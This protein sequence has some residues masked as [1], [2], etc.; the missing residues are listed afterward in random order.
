MRLAWSNRRVTAKDVKTALSQA[1]MFSYV[2]H[3]HRLVQATWL[4]LLIL[5]TNKSMTQS[6]RKD[7]AG[8]ISSFQ[9]FDAVSFQY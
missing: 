1:E 9:F 7:N 6:H 8:I 3:F 2:K 4:R 5:I